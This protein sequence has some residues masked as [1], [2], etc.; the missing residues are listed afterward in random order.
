LMGLPLCQACEFCGAHRPADDV[1]CKNGHE[2]GPGK[3]TDWAVYG[4]SGIV[5]SGNW[6]KDLR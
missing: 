2:Y 6:N 5:A 3:D 4:E 1:I